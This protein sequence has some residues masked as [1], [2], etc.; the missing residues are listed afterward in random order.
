PYLA[1][2]EARSGN[3]MT[4]LERKCIGAPLNAV[5]GMAIHTTAGNDAGTPFQTACY[6]CV[7][8]WNGNGASAHFAISGDG[9]IIQFV[10]ANVMAFAQ[11]DPGNRQ[12]ISVEVD[13]N[14]VLPMN[15]N[16]LTA[17][18]NLFRW[19]C[20]THAIPPQL[21]TGCLF[22]SSPQFDEITMTVCQAS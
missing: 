21:E 3:R 5:H 12:W 16:Q 20:A 7:Q 1:L 18:K 22:P 6:R 15:Y 8:T 17:A 10:P 9:T 19:V 4:R 11:H 14:G 2:Q 13:N